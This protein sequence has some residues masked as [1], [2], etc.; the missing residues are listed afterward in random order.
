MEKIFEAFENGKIKNIFKI[1]SSKDWFVV[2]LYFVLILNSY[3][4]ADCQWKIEKPELMN[5]GKIPEYFIKKFYRII[6]YTDLNINFTTQT[7]GFSR[8]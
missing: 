6:L 5:L 7:R 8:Y 2:I 3:N 4:L 1:K